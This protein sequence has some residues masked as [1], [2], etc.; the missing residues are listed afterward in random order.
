MKKIISTL[1]ISLVVSFI[2]AKPVRVGYFK[3]GGRVMKYTSDTGKKSGFSYEYLQTLASYTDWDFEYVYGYWDELY[4]KLISGEIDILTDV[5]YSEARSKLFDY[6]EYPMAQENYYL[7]V[8]KHNPD[9]VAENLS[10]LNG[11]S[12]ALG[13]GTYQHGLLMEWLKHHD[14]KLDISLVPFDVV[15]EDEFNKGN[16]DLYLA[17]DL[18]SNFDW[19]PIVKIGSSDIFVAVSKARP[20][21]LKELNEAQTALYIS[22]PYYNNNLWGKYFSNTSITRRLSQTEKDWLS[23]KT[24]LN[25]GCF[26]N[27]FLFS[28]ENRLHDN[29]GVV[30]FILS[31]LKTQFG[32][33]ELPVKYFYYEDKP[34][35]INALKS[36]EI[37][38]AFPFLY[39]VY[40]AEQNKVALSMPA[41]SASFSLIYVQ[42]TP[43]EKFITKVGLLRGKRAA[44][45]FE[46]TEMSTHSEIT[47][48]D[49]MDE[50]LNALIAGKIYSVVV[51]TSAAS[52][53]LFGR[54]KYR[55]LTMINTDSSA[56]LCFASDNSNKAVISLMNKL[57]S[58]INKNDINAELVKYS[59]ADKA[60]SFYDF[61]DDYS[62]FILTGIFLVIILIVAL[63]AALKYIQ[64]LMN[65]DSVTHLLTRHSLKNYIKEFMNQ[66]V[67]LKEN[68][69][70]LIFD[71]DDFKLINESF[72]HDVGDEV[73][74]ITSEIIQKGVTARDKVFRWGD[75]EFLVLLQADKKTAEAAADRIRQHIAEQVFAEN[76]KKFKV[77]ITGGLSS[78]QSGIEWTEMLMDAEEKLYEGKT[79]GKNIIVSADQE[80]E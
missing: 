56:D 31:K 20:D 50:C 73:L 12:I 57:I 21:L 8:N 34:E 65:F 63:V 38:I 36:G 11:K 75:G 22:N 77:T 28:P 67:N 68:F 42:G 60:Y 19:E 64:I 59:I 3:D 70:V 4:Q 53:F 27:D 10:S 78:F 2:N 33:Y 1:L 37:D 17:V 26:K 9:V 58:V 61:W 29:S 62:V 6:S 55:C 32:L 71:L 51:N 30:N 35:I 5:S 74:R 66:A 43:Y 72:G 39:D 16:Y 25:V 24:S 52:S 15:S 79:K 46:S 76:D 47:Y 41:L 18:I 54:K 14:V 44:E 13:K 7:Y 48:F 40:S 23:E 69:S 49:T 45:Y 80:E